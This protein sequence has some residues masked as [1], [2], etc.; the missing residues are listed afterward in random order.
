[1]RSLRASFKLFLF[2]IAIVLVIPLQTFVM[3]FHKGRGAYILPTIWHRFVCKVFNIRIEIRGTPNKGAQTLYM[4]NHVSYLDVPVLA[5]ILPASFLAKQEVE[6]WPL[7]GF[8]SK[9]QQCAYIERRTRAIAREKSKLENFISDGRSLIVFPEGTSTSGMSVKPFKSSLFS[10]AEGIGKPIDIQPVTIAVVETD[11]KKPVTKEE[12]DI[13]AWP[14]EM[15]TP[16][17]I[18]LWLFGKSSGARLIVTFHPPFKA[19]ADSDR[20]V[21]AKTCHDSVSNGLNAAL[22]A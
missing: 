16:L 2:L 7:F 6:S 12:F 4:S 5:S 19:Y 9:L 1:M 17:H 8:L 3:L 22:A 21:L 14:L 15:E 20:K 13:Y 10:L 11:G 18:H